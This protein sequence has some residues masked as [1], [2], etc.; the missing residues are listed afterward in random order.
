MSKYA[1]AFGEKDNRSAPCPNCGGPRKVDTRYEQLDYWEEGHAAISGHEEY[2]V[3]QCRGCETVFFAQSSSCSEDYFHAYD[4]DTGDEEL[5]WNY[6]S[7]FWPQVEDSTP[8]SWAGFEL[9]RA[10]ETLADLLDGIYNC[11]RND[12]PI[13]A[14]IGCRTALD[15]VSELLGVDPSL[16]FSEKLEALR[17]NG[18]ISGKQKGMLQILIDAG[19]AAAH[20]G[21]KPERQ[22]LSTMIEILE[23]LIRDRFVLGADAKR[24]EASIPSKQ[25]TSS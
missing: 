25:K 3:F 8:P 13:F 7:Q 5:I 15:R 6:R 23:A 18:Y 2:Y 12:M 16:G 22:E 14:A 21:W 19:S 24:L 10:D 4:P 1:G 11:T 17:R 9:R 20:R